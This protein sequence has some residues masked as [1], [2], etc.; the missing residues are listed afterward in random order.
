MF[1]VSMVK[2][3]DIP[4]SPSEKLTDVSQCY[5]VTYVYAYTIFCMIRHSMAV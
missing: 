4:M 3:P 1:I 5:F 2:I